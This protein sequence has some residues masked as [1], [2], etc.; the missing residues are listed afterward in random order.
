[1]TFLKYL[2]GSVWLGLC[3][4]DLKGDHTYHLVNC[5]KLGAS[6]NSSVWNLK[7]S[8]SFLANF[9]IPATI[10]HSTQA[11]ESQ[12]YSKIQLQGTPKSC[13]WENPKF[14]VDSPTQSLF[15]CQVTFHLGRIRQVL[16]GCL[17]PVFVFFLSLGWG[18][19]TENAQEVKTVFLAGQWQ[20]PW[21]KATRTSAGIFSHGFL[22]QECCPHLKYSQRGIGLPVRTTACR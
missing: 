10:P 5:G 9:R 21:V 18:G 3:P 1:M 6:S 7:I 17:V 12:A 19:K 2:N 11:V 14:E 13:T 4:K 8:Q 20:E 15:C 16:C 22:P